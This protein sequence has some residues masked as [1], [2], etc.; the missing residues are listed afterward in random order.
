[1]CCFTSHNPPSQESDYITRSQSL[2]RAEFKVI[3]QS[4]ELSE[5]I[6]ILIQSVAWGEKR[7]IKKKTILTTC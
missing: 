5:I 7:Y 2:F 6:D 1:M 3:V 4:H